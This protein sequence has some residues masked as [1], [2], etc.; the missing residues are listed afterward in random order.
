ME[1]SRSYFCLDVLRVG[2][3]LIL[4]MVM[5][6]QVN[7]ASA[8]T[9]K[10][11]AKATTDVPMYDR[12]PFFSTGTGWNYGQQVGIVR[13]GVAVYIC[14][15]TTVSFGF[16]SQQWHQIAYWDRQW[17]YAW[18]PIGSIELVSRNDLSPSIGRLLQYI[19]GVSEAVAD[20]EPPPQGSL[21]PPPPSAE[22]S[23]GAGPPP[24][25]GAA[26]WLFYLVL[27]VAMIVG[28]IAKTV[29]NVIQAERSAT[30]KWYLR[31]GC[32][33][34]LVSP[35]VFLAFMQTAD[36]ASDGGTRSFVVLLLLAFQNGFFWQTVF[37]T[38]RQA[39]ASPG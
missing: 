27:F 1:W 14:R 17:R 28:M 16:L 22:S 2:V 12:P 38:R 21:P 30:W 37:D 20:A 23:L 10:E 32:I 3:M 24:D 7:E 33:P 11:K 25:A 36:F 8:Q 5:L 18:V 35:V 15:T 29:A 13:Q 34:L 9:C 19:L 39:V 26:L 4:A 6:V 31:Q